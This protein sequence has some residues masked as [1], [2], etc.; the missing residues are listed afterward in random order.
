MYQSSCESQLGNHE[1]VVTSSEREAQKFCKNHLDMMSSS[2]AMLHKVQGKMAPQER[3][4]AGPLSSIRSA[5]GI[6]MISWSFFNGIDWEYLT[7]TWITSLATSSSFGKSGGGFS[8]VTV[9]LASISLRVV[10]FGSWMKNYNSSSYL[11][12]F[13]CAFLNGILSSLRQP[14]GK[15][16]V[17]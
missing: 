7:S 4:L 13:T 1:L 9:S 2:P 8:L 14:R 11:K 10:L 6:T 3:M 5:V 16:T 15:Q 17:H 12:F